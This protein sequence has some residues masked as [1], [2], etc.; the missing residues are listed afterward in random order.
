MYGYQMDYAPD[1]GGQMGGGMTGG[2]M[3]GGN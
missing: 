3:A 2:G 1:F